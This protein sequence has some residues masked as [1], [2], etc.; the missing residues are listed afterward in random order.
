MNKINSGKRWALAWGYVFLIFATLNWTR[1]PLTFL[2]DH[3][4]LRPTLF[5]LFAICFGSL[6]WHLINLKGLQVWRISILVII[7]LTTYGISK[8]LASPEEQIHFLEY[9]LVGVLFLRSL[10][11]QWGIQWKSYGMSLIMAG[12]VGWLDEVIQGILPT[13]TYDVRDIYLNIISALM[14]L[15]IF[16]LYPPK[17]GLA[18]SQVGP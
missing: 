8:D 5:L 13:R 3:G 14:G 6:I 4:L 16:S 12:L 17:S 11:A 18:K 2:R 10:E 9:G 7:F 1:V 15:I